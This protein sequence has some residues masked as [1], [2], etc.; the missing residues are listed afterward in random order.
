MGSLIVR[1][2]LEQRALCVPSCAHIHQVRRCGRVAHTVH[3]RVGIRALAGSRTMGLSTFGRACS[4]Q[5]RSESV[6][7]LARDYFRLLCRD[8]Q[9]KVDGGRLGKG[10]RHDQV[11]LKPEMPYSMPNMWRKA[12]YNSLLL[13]FQRSDGSQLIFGIGIT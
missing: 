5:L 12:N 11:G 9:I 10:R 2:G 4:Y 7:K 6:G 13:S 1:Q 8:G 3:L